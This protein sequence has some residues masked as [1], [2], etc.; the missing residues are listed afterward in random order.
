MPQKSSLLIQGVFH[1][2]KRVMV[3][4]A[5]GE[6]HH[7]EFH[8]SCAAEGYETFEYIMAAPRTGA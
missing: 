4:I 1:G 8:S 5:A 7:S 3:T 2:I 6:D